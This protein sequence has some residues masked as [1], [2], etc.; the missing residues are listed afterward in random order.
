MNFDSLTGKLKIRLKAE[1]PGS[2]SHELLRAKPIGQLLPKFDHKL[3]PKLGSV[4]ILLYEENGL[5]KFPL[6][7]RP[8]YTGAHSGQVS[9]PG[10]K[11]ELDEDVFQAALR[12]AEEEIGVNKNDIEIIGR[13]SDFNVLPSNFLVT[14]VVASIA[15]V[16]QFIPDAHEVAKV[17]QA[18]LSELVHDDAIRESE[19]LA[20]G[21]YR[22]IAPHF[23][24]EEEI[25][26][27]ATAMML[28]ELRDIIKDMKEG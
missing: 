20:A 23:F 21:L 8:T 12:E 4:L 3:P 25:V 18:D 24:V 2:A 13:L 15:Y 19:I 6:I 10:G 9:F 5:I 28:N 17:I 7:K 27:G 14:P 16:P 11:V 26:W 22:M 1:L